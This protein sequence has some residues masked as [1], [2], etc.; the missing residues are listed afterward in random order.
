MY[1][2]PEQTLEEA[3]ADVRIAL[4]ARARAY[5]PLPAHPRARHRVSRPAAAAAGRGRGVSRCRP[6]ASELLAARG[7]RAIRS[8]AYARRGARAG[9][10][11]TTGC[12][13]TTWA[14]APA[15]T[16]SSPRRCPDA[17]CGPKSRKQPREYLERSSDVAASAGRRRAP[18]RR[19]AA[20]LPFEFMLNALRL[21]EGFASARFRAADRACR[22]RLGGAGAAALRRGAASRPR[23][24]GWRPTRAGQALPKR[25]AGGFSGMSLC[26]RASA[27]RPK[28]HL[29]HIAPALGQMHL[30]TIEII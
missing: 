29:Q 14:W 23:P 20:S 13:A 11:S 18:V 17:I 28:R 26:T 16:A 19:P 4:R 5:L 6:N 12:S 1:A 30:I 9:T 21:N 25:S 10:I 15:P 22:W 2:L 27:P 3:L 7:L 24:R 8:S